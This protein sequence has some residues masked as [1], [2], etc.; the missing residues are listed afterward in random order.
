MTFILK[1]CFLISESHHVL[2][3][4]VKHFEKKSGVKILTSPC[5]DDWELFK[6]EASCIQLELCIYL[7][8]QTLHFLLKGF[9]IF[10]RRVICV[11]CASGEVRVLKI[12]MMACETQVGLLQVDFPQKPS[13]PPEVSS[14]SS[15]W[16]VTPASCVTC[17]RLLAVGSHGPCTC[18][19]APGIST[20]QRQPASVVPRP[21]RGPRSGGMHVLD[22]SSGSVH[23]STEES[24]F[25]FS[26]HEIDT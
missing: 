3:N 9:I 24:S 26:E 11:N 25:V 21:A 13:S 18:T 1:N 19:K 8:H 22:S 16:P 10:P 5:S 23:S 15:H 17:P 12:R 7:K 20:G 2:Q 6:S 14:L 4:P